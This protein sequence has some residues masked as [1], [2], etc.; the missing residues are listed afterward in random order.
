[1]GLQAGWL[2]GGGVPAS[3]LCMCVRACVCAKC[4]MPVG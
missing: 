2:R 4:Q 1:M 3:L